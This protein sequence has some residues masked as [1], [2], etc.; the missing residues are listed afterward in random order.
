MTFSKLTKIP[1]V[2]QGTEVETIKEET[3]VILYRLLQEGLTN[4]IKHAHATHV[5]VSFKQDAEQIEL[6]LQ[7]DG[8]GFDMAGETLSGIGHQNMMERLRLI[9]GKLSIHSIIGKGTN[10][11]AS[12]PKEAVI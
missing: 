7:D 4:I 3:G 8:I 11:T 9:N 5:W 10:L 2:Y 12:I 6:T 1:V